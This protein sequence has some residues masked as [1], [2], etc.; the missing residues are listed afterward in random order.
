[1]TTDALFEYYLRTLQT[2]RE[3]ELSMFMNWIAN[4][5]CSGDTDAPLG[6]DSVRVLAQLLREVAWGSSVEGVLSEVRLINAEEA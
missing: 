5:L 2:P 3:R 6:A 1:M 4:L